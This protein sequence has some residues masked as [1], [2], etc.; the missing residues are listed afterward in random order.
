[1]RMGTATWMAIAMLT[2]VPAFAQTLA[3]DLEMARSVIQT[4]RKMIVAKNMD[5]SDWESEAF[6][7]VYNAYHE[8]LRQVNDTRA[9]LMLRLANELDTLSSWQAEDLLK[10]FL[11]H[12]LERAKLRKKYVKK[13]NKVLPLR[14]V[15]RYYQ[16]ENKIDIILDFGLARAIPLVR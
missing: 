1:M 4:E 14:K 11:E 6:W 8:D 12:Q 7:P 2:N 9:A 5:F 13:F 15:V 10:Q 16:I 3:D